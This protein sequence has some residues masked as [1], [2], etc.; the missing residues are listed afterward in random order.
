MAKCSNFKSHPQRLEN[1]LKALGKSQSVRDHLKK[2]DISKSG[3][4]KKV[5]DKM[6]ERASLTNCSIQEFL[7]LVKKLV[8]T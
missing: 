8:Q 5:V 1:L 6:L 3:L 2:I 7:S 4:E